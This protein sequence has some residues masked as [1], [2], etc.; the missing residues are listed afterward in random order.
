M[1]SNIKPYKESEKGKK[2]QVTEMF[3][4]I[5]GNYD[6][7]NRVITF[8]LDKGWRRKVVE[9]VNSGSPKRIL[10]VATGTGDMAIMFAKGGAKNVVGQDISSGMLEVAKVKSK[11]MDLDERIQ[12]QIGDA[13]NMP[14]DDGHFD[15]VT[16]SYGIRNFEDLRKGLREILRVLNE[17][18]RLVILETSVPKSA[19]MRFGYGIHTK[20]FIPLMGRLFSK[21]KRAYSYLSDSAHVFPH[22]E[23]LKKILLKVGYS[24]V[25]VL[26]QSGGISTIYEAKK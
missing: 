4:N 7:M 6:W 3:D 25:D 21:D 18:G 19:F 17:N 13:E 8:G 26:P 12:F 16:V 22:G 9:I 10:D 1:D 23:A 2:D 24:E 20:V 5:S 11:K 14:F 15:V